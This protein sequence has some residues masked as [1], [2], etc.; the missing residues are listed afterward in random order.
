MNYI[1]RRVGNNIKR[2]VGEKLCAMRPELLGENKIGIAL[3]ESSYSITVRIRNNV[4]WRIPALPEVLLRMTSILTKQIIE[5][6][7][8][9]QINE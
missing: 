7:I 2:K 3:R 6:Q 8:K 5:S 1:K 4:G 9:L